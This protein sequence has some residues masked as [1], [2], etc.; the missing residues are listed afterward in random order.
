MKNNS[1]ITVTIIAVLFLIVML[2]ALKFDLNLV[3]LAFIG[4]NVLFVVLVYNILKNGK[5]SGKK[6]EDGH[7]YEDTV[8]KEK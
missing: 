3:Y 7:W 8:N 4:G 6:F 2:P 5:A 1:I